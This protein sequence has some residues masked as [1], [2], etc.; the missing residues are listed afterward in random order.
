MKKIIIAP[1][2]FKGTLSSVD[3]CKIIK[4]ELLKRNS[5][6]NITEIPLADGG[7]GTCDAFFYALGGK[8]LHK[9][10]KSPLMRDITGEYL[11]LP[12]GTAVIEMASAS[13]LT[14]EKENDAL[15]ATTYGTGQLI[16]DAIENGCKKIIIGIGGSATTDGGTGCMSALGVKFKDKDEKELFPCGKTLGLIEN[17][18]ISSLDKRLKETEITVLCDVKNPLYGENGAAFVFSSQKGAKGEDI[19]LLDNGLRNL[20]EVFKRQFSKDYSTQPGSGAAGGLG[21]ALI[22]FLGADLKDGISCVLDTANFNEEIKDC[23][24]VITGEGKMDSQS[25]M[26]KVPFGVAKR[27]KGVRVIAIVGLCDIDKEIAKAHGIDEIIETNPERLPFDEVKK[28]A[29]EM[30][31]RAC[32]KVN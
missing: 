17:I 25:L 26:G 6:L 29:R 12:D 10:V 8:K 16:A 23:E 4:S 18:D 19:K 2:S 27:S 11:I 28:K 5:D 9:T 20:A 3:V 7:E 15:L 1:D 24:L 14:L 32:R 13:G 31:E 22:S 30:L 21:F